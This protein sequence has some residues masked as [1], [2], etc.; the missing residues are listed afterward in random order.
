MSSS[1]DSCS[2]SDSDTIEMDSGDESDLS[3]GGMEELESEDEE[4]DDVYVESDS[5]EESSLT[6]SSS[7]RTMFSKQEKKEPTKEALNGN[8]LTEAG[9]L[10]TQQIM[11]DNLMCKNGVV[12][13]KVMQIDASD[14]SDVETGKLS[15]M[16]GSY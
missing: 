8:S 10:L 15:P 5:E 6:N 2:A 9:K 14:V 11:R 1:L 3:E 4:S 16:K 13:G 12:F 7:P